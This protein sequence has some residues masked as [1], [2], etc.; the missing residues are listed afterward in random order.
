MLALQHVMHNYNVIR[1][2][3]NVLY[4]LLVKTL[5]LSYH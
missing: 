1:R 3:L 2:N 5:F 4:E